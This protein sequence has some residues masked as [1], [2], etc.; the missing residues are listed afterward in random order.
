[1]RSK[2]GEKEMEEINLKEL[3]GKMLDY[4]ARNNLTMT[5]MSKK[6]KISYITWQ[7]VEKQKQMPNRF[8]AMKILKAIGE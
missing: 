5:E 3:S 2:G 1:M 7:Y 8:T 6:A 4:R